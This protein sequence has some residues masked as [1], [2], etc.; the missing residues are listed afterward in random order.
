MIT[1]SLRDRGILKFQS[2]FFLPEH[3]KMLNEHWED[4][5]KV[6]RPELDEQ[7]LADLNELVKDAVY[8]QD[9]VHVEYYSGGHILD[10]EGRISLIDPLKKCIHIVGGGAAAGEVRISLKDV[11]DIKL[12]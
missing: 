11:I 1:L 12:I 7:K 6:Q 8:H 2:A 4:A 9:L 5:E 10:C 3:V